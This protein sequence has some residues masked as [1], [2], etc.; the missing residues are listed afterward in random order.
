[1]RGFCPDQN[2]VCRPCLATSMSR[3]CITSP[4]T[5]PAYREENYT[6]RPP[7]GRSGASGFQFLPVQR[8]RSSTRICSV[9]W[10]RAAAEGLWLWQI[11]YPPKHCRIFRF[12]QFHIRWGVGRGVGLASDR[13]YI[14]QSNSPHRCRDRLCCSPVRQTLGKFGRHINTITDFIAARAI[15]TCRS[16]KAPSVAG[17][18]HCPARP[19]LPSGLSE[20]TF[21]NASPM[22][23]GPAHP[24]RCQ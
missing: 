23:D 6:I 7:R 13:W 16:T 20:L 9:R 3:M 17:C 4:G 22:A 19:A 12:H 21:V 5:V 2:C 15:E 10:S 14:M 18:R 8:S 1:M 11:F 24:D